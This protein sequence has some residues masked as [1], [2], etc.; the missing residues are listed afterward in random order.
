MTIID[1]A[2]IISPASVYEVQF[3]FTSKIPM[4]KMITSLNQRN[5]FEE[6]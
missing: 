1:R 5:V 2:K 6:R 3:I 4:F